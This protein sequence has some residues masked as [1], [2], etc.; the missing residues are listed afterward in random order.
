MGSLTEAQHTVRWLTATRAAVTTL[1]VGSVGAAFLWG[2]LPFPFAPFLVVVGVSYVLTGVYWALIPRVR[3]PAR[4][5]EVQIY[6]D[7]G[8]ETLLIYLTGGPYSVFPFIYLLSILAM[9][10][11]VAPRRSFAAATMAVL[12]HGVLLVLQ[13]HRFLPPVSALPG[14]RDLVVEGSLTILLIGGNVCA[15]YTVAYLATYLAGRLRQARGEAR[16]SEASLAE[17]QVLHEDIVQ[18]VASG[19]V[20]VD[21]DGCITTVNHTAETLSRRSQA[22]LR[23]ERWEAVFAGAPSFGH[24]WEVLARRGRSPFR[25][26]AHLVRQDGS[27]VPVGVSASF[28]RRELG[29]ICSFQDLTDIRRM[30]ERVRHADRLAAV[31]RF[32]AGLAHEIRNPL[33]SIRG[34]VEVLRESLAPRGDDRRLMDIVLRE[35]DRLDGIISE[36]LEFSRPQSLVRIDT[37]IVGMLEEILLLLSHQCPSTVRVVRDYGEPTIKAWVDAGQMRQALWN[38]CRNALEAMP[39]GGE[40]R[41]RAHIEA[42]PGG[43]DG[44]E[45]VVEDTG[46]GV[47]P[48][49]VPRLFEPF[50]TTKPSGTGLGLAI[51]HRIMEDHGGEIRVES[52]PGIGTRFSITIP[53]EAR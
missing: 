8:L 16:R 26:E 40:L 27:R 14:Q 3:T 36:F 29:L 52:E 49:Q 43:S 18:S 47:P 46:V 19:L 25:F 6:V 50:Y 23:R 39:Q 15:C 34:S 7:L 22:D 12:L 41:V 51:V 42:R 11:V 5:A 28:L 24:V 30:E 38:L 35:S 45:I 10:I 9:S 37:D 48:E 32:A 20:T 2:S 1:L 17:L 44:V 31:G 33:G 4:L 13:F 53:V 21:R